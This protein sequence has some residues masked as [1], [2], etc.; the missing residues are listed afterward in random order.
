MKEYERVALTKD[1][2]REAMQAAGKKQA[3]L[4]RDTGLNRGTISRY[5]SGEVEPRQDA[6]YKLAAALGVNEM[7][8]WGYSVPMERRAEAKK[9]DDLVVLIAKMRN[10]PEFFEVVSR[11]ASL[12][13]AEYES[14][15]QLLG[16]LGSR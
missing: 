13:P 4:V 12:A 9:N 1:R 5:L 3:D 14:I 10:D 6:T 16:A 15:K 11:L 7:W 2:I 8:L